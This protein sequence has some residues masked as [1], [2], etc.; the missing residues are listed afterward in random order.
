MTNNA[1]EVKLTQTA[2]NGTPLPQTPKAVVITESFNLFG[3][4][5]DNQFDRNHVHY[6][7]KKMIYS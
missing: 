2:I 1:D 6:N 7:A 5:K 4:S 3:G